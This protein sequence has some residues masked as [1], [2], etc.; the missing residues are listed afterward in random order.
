MTVKVLWQPSGVTLEQ[1]GT[2]DHI[3]NSD[4]DTPKVAL[5]IRMLSMDTPETKNIARGLSK[6]EIRE[7]WP[8]LTDWFASGESPVPRG[9]AEHLAPPAGS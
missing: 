4:G 7:F 3:E 2:R 1:K 8:Q 6:E 9:L 5:P